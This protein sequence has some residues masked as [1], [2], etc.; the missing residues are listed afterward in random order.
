MKKIAKSEPPEGLKQWKRNNAQSP[1]NLYYGLAEFPHDEVLKAL[2]K[3][4]G[5]ICAYTL[6]RICS[7]S[8]HV[9]HLKPQTICKE[10]DRQREL[11]NQPVLREDIAWNNIVA[12]FPEPQVPAAPEY[13]AV[14]KGGWWDEAKFVSPLLQ[15]C[16]QRFRFSADGKIAPADGDDQAAAET[17]KKIGL[18]NAKLDELRRAAFLHAGIHKRADKPITSVTK[19]EQLMAKWA[20]RDNKTESF[21][22]FCT[23]LIQVAKDYVQFLRDRGPNGG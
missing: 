3:E 14:K 11:S 5:N 22:E 20:N 17:I 9:E 23:P 13:G 1:Q 12:C 21:A 10:E 16:E 19:V 6:K 7:T 2:L 18:D 15:E 4:Q 8:A